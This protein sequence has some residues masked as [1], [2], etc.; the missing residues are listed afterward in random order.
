MLGGGGVGVTGRV[1][2]GVNVGVASA[3]AVEVALANWAL[4][5]AKKLAWSNG[6][7]VIVGQTGG[8]VLV[9]M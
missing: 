7:G 6:V 3:S 4:I 9:T 2:L 1:G 8:G 5:V